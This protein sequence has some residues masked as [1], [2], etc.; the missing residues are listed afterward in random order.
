MKRDAKKTAGTTAS[1]GLRLLEVAERGP[2]GAVLRALVSEQRAA[3]AQLLME[4]DDSLVDGDTLVEEA[5]APAEDPGSARDATQR[6]A[7]FDAAE[8]LARAASQSASA[9]PPGTL[10]LIAPLEGDTPI[11]AAYALR[12]DA[13]ARR[14]STARSADDERRV[15]RLL[16]E[17]MGV[18]D[19]LRLL[20]GGPGTGKTHTI[21][22]LVAERFAAATS[23]SQPRIHVMAPTGRAAARLREQLAASTQTDAA[24]F[25]TLSVSTIH[26][27]LRWRPTPGAPFAHTASDPLPT[28]LAIVD[29]CS[30]VDLSLM[31]RLLEAM[32]P[33][34]TLM[35]VGD[36]DQ[37][38]SV[39]SGSVFRDCCTAPALDG[40]LVRLTH[41]YRTEGDPRA[42]WLASLVE[43]VRV[44]DAD[45]AIAALREQQ[46]LIEPG[47]STRGA[48]ARAD[49]GARAGV[50]ARAGTRART[51]AARLTELAVEL[52]APVYDGIL[53]AGADDP[54]AAFDALRHFR[55]LSAT[56]GGDGGV[57]VISQ[58]LDERLLTGSSEIGR[59]VMMLENDREADLANGDLG[60][61][62]SDGVIVGRGADGAPRVIPRVSL[63]AHESAWAISIHKSQ[64]SEFDRVLVVLPDA[65]SRILSRQLLYTAL[66]RSRGQVQVVATEA[67]VRRAVDH[68]IRRMGGLAEAISQRAG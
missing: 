47:G 8:T 14:L 9:H 5:E 39:E 32:P 7:A 40:A 18:E 37:L 3:L 66:T 44:G 49:A 2:D 20:T 41:N 30:M 60:V 22:R 35:L 52:A 23:G 13:G 38:A 6:R 27:A 63:P 4:I 56:R 36:A 15:A 10:R 11:G 33:H 1:A 24:W 48:D 68:S 43:A 45:R 21:A 51:S 65:A 59:H 67:S 64:G 12:G 19:R 61:V 16:L 50:D 54:L 25:D 17:R 29:E 62:V 34:A 53:S 28:D 57:E 31:R 46:A 55:V 42:A 26:A 58:R